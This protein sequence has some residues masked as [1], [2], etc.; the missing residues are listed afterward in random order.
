MKTVEQK[1]SIEDAVS[2]AF[3]DLQALGEELREA[4][5]NTPESLQASAAAQARDEA[6]N[7][8][9]GLNEPSIPDALKDAFKVTQIT[10][11]VRVLTPKQQ[12]RL[13][14]SARRDDACEWLSA[15]IDFLADVEGDNA[16]EAAEFVI[17]LEQLRDDADSVEFPGRNG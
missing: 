8:L 4:Y 14:R 5:D 12:A 2:S 10:R 6:A 9:E 17:E 15:V 13:S 3:G 1:M 7:I 11:L 16:D